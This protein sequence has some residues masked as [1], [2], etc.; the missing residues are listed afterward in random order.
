MSLDLSDILSFL[1]LICYYE[2]EIEILYRGG[3]VM[4][5]HV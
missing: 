5:E 2:F 1:L 4:K 3:V